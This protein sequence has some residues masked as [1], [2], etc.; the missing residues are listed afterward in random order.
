PPSATGQRSTTAP[1][2]VYST[3]RAIAAAA[4]T[5]VSEPLN[6]SGAQITRIAK[7]CSV[8]GGTAPQRSIAEGDASMMRLAMEQA[9]RAAELGEVPVGAVIYR[10]NQVLA[11][12]HNL[13]ESASAPTAHAEIVALR[14]AATAVG[15]WRL[16][17]CSMAVTL[18]PCPMCAG[19]LINARVPR[20]V[21]GAA[22]PKMGCV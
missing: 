5:A 21:Y 14:A 19:G 3:P 16:E 20:L 13:R 4:C 11:Q 12:A 6:L 22:D 10:D 7:E 8:S 2:T 9:A 1:G 18:E 17:G 15:S